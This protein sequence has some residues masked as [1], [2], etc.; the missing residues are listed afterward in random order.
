MRNYITGLILSM[1]LPSAVFGQSIAFHQTCQDL[2][3][4]LESMDAL[5]VSDSDIWFD[6]GGTMS[7]TLQSST[8]ASVDIVLSAEEARHD[9]RRSLRMVSLPDMNLVSEADYQTLASLLNEKLTIGISSGLQGKWPGHSAE[10][11]ELSRLSTVDGYHG[12]LEIIHQ[13]HGAP[14]KNVPEQ[15]QATTSMSSRNP[16]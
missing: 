7:F 15:R 2:I 3:N 1:L 11:V 5:V 4:S 8:G 14:L 16:N 9:L 13:L 12:D 10:A 6:R